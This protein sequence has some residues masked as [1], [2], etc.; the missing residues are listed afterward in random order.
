M[1]EKID[2]VCREKVSKPEAINTVNIFYYLGNCLRREIN[3]R[4]FC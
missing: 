4:K 3:I 1:E 2:N